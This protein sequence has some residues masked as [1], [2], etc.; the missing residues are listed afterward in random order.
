MAKHIAT[1]VV[2]CAFLQACGFGEQ[3]DD[4]GNY[5]Q[6]VKLRPAG[7]IEPV[8]AF[9]PYEAFVY[10]A[11][12][13]RSPFEL[14]V[15]V[16]R[17]VV[18]NSNSN[19]KP[20]ENRE[21]EYLETFDMSSLSMV[22]SLKKGGTLWALIQDSEGVVHWVTDGNYVGKNHGR[23]ISTQETKLELIEIVSDGLKGWVE[24]PR[25]LALSEKE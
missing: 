14:P 13:K 20:D 17:R 3:S 10:S 11:T 4:I 22:G 7:N 23:I 24:R 2:F 15:Q 21:K 19:I 5:I 6:Q 8:P 18:A 16:D 12:A 1:C 9:R 25:V